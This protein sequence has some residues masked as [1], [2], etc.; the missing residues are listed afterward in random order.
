VN[1]PIA[2]NHRG[3]S[4]HKLIACVMGCVLALG[5]VAARAGD[6]DAGQ[7]KLLDDAKSY[8]DKIAT[9]LK[10]AKDSAGP[11]NTQPKGSKAKLAMMRLNS[12]RQ[13]VPQ[14]TARLEKLPA[15]HA[16][17]QAVQ[18]RLDALVAEMDQLE[19][20]ITGKSTELREKENTGVKL[21]YKQEE[22]LKNARFY[23]R[24]VQGYAQGLSGLVEEIRP[25]EN[26]DLVDHRKLQQ[27]AATINKAGERVKYAQDGLANL[28]ADG[29]GVQAASDELKQAVA[30]I[31]G[32]IKF[33][34]PIH[35]HVMDLINPANYPELAADLERLGDLAGMYSNTRVFEMDR[36]RAAEVTRE[37]PAAMAER[38]RV[39]KKY[40]PLIKQRTAEGERVEK[41][42]NHLTVKFLE[43]SKEAER[44]K[45]LLP[46]QLD[47]EIA[48]ARD[49]A[50]DAVERQRPAYFAHGIPQHLNWVDEKLA[51][52]DVL[53]PAG[54]KRYHDELAKLRK[55]L[56]AGAAALRE[57]II[58]ENNLPEDNYTGPDRAELSKL[59][60]DALRKIHP[61]LEVLTIR[62]P[63]KQWKR[64]VLWRFE[65]ATAYKVDHS[66]L[67][68]Q[69]IVK[70]D[71]KLAE[72]QPVTIWKNHISNDE[73]KAYPL[74]DKDW[75]LEPSSLMLRE[76][77]K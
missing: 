66:K 57:K 59:A 22:Q 67:Q 58:A 53:D 70:H 63:A 21:D 71:D 65:N 55:E 14:V 47:K 37:G 40:L 52:Y 28:P 13:P 38:D 2:L 48:E 11:G 41:L 29:R 64:E 77:V 73:L 24:E 50:K 34:Q 51:L 9:N 69:L 62:I 32:S 12:A 33:L 23:I 8:L 20:R 15:D 36:P 7:Q 26:H 75:E 74:F 31:Q 1:T 17:V 10:Y 6:L 27:A 60:E 4:Y 35:T 3:G 19:R 68:L 46:Q 18:A 25:I 30:S 72:I 39:V 49:I 42:G 16:D 44:Y 54:A 61:Q 45:Q 76:K 5:A 43:F 56:K